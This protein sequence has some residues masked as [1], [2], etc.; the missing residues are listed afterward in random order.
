MDVA[1][2]DTMNSGEMPGRS[3]GRLQNATDSAVDTV[4]VDMAA[5][6]PDD[7]TMTPPLHV[8]AARSARRGHRRPCPAPARGIV[9][10]CGHNGHSSV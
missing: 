1:R 10:E 2:R 5:G 8:G 6:A 7:G 9:V 3:A 4:Q